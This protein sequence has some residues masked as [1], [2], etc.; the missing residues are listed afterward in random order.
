M[1]RTA[2]AIILLGVTSC[3]LP[4]F[5]I[6]VEHGAGGIE[7]ERTGALYDTYENTVGVELVWHA[8]PRL[9]RAVE[10]EG[11]AA[12]DAD[13]LR[14]WI[15]R[16]DS[17]RDGTDERDAKTTPTRGALVTDG[18][19]IGPDLPPDFEHPD[20]PWWGGMLGKV[21]TGVGMALVA[22]FWSWMEF[23]GFRSRNDDSDD[24]C[25]D[26]E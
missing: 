26:D 1:K 2:L 23:K 15:R 20:E 8:S 9:R 21:L 25:N 13:L 17:E 22:G 18:N 24:D 10:G 12:R 7:H 16:L 19:L 14:E 4:T 11:D 3:A 6:Y 5:G